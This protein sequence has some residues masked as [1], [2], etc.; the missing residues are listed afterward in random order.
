M[1][2]DL[3]DLGISEFT[4]WPW[5]FERDVESY[6]S[7]GIDAIEITEAKLEP[8]RIGEQI[9]LAARNSLKVSSIQ[10]KVHSLYP[11]LLQP[12]PR[13]PSD[14]LRH[15]RGS[16]EAIAPH[17]P[18][19][20]PFV[21]I[22]GAPPHGDIGAVL[23]TARREFAELARHAEAHGVRI[24]LEPLNPTLMNI[25]SSIWGLGEALD[26]VEHVAHPAFGVC[27][28]TWNI[29]QSPHLDDAIARAGERI[30]LVQ[31]SDWRA[32][33]GHY[34]RLVPGQGTIPLAPIVGAVRSA[35][36][37]GPYVVEIFSS[38]SL[39]GSLWRADLDAVI[40]RSIVGFDRIWDAVVAPLR[41]A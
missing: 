3:Y 9:A 38:E 6:L 23:D 26:I 7:H 18:H 35:G 12:E 27:I 20:T 33:L 11:T 5:T 21:V 1:Q 30:F 10:A 19:G 8:T 17:V 34:D 15:I 25:D 16:I 14:R 22:T 4:T 29:W 37:A 32:P 36:Y 24:A 2:S 28:D 41:P 31:V 13:D 40:D 39:Q